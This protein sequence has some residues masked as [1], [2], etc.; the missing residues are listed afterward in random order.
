MS[1]SS[2]S[3]S[4]SDADDDEALP[5]EA[6]SA[7]PRALVLHIFSLL[8][9]DVRLRCAEVCKAWRD[10]LAERSLWATCQLKAA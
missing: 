2:S 5:C 8:P 9:V 7:L 1:S 10:A 6:L 4:S 3:T